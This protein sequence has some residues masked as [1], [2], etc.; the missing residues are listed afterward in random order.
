MEHAGAVVPV[1]EHAPLVRPAL[2]H[3]VVQPERHQLVQ[4]LPFG[5]GDVRVPDVG[6]RVEHVLVG[7][8]DIHVPAHDSR[9][10]PSG[11]RVAQ[12]A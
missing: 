4:R 3:D 8:S 7:W 6:L 10:G 2:A 11:D 9:L 1:G 5:R 12:D